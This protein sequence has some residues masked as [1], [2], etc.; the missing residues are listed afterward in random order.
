MIFACSYI[1]W[2]PYWIWLVEGYVHGYANIQLGSLKHWLPMNHRELPELLEIEFEA[3]LPGLIDLGRKQHNQ[4]YTQHPIIRNFPKETVRELL[5]GRQ[6]IQVHYVV[7]SGNP[8]HKNQ[9]YANT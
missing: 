1:S 9:K 2:F 5:G 4:L 8:A 3:I 6:Q 7:N